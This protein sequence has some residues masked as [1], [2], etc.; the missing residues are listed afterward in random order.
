MYF[1]EERIKRFAKDIKCCI[2]IKKYEIKNI[3]IRYGAVPKNSDLHSINDRWQDYVSG[4]SW[5]N[6]SADVY[7]LFE[8]EII[9]PEEFDGGKVVLN[10]RTNRNGWNALNPQMLLYVNSKEQQ[11]LDT[12]HTSF[13]LDDNAKAGEVYGIMIYAF[14]G[15]T[16]NNYGDNSITDV[17]FSADIAMVEPLAEA[18]YYNLSIPLQLLSQLPEGCTDR[19]KVLGILNETVNIVD[20]RIPGS[21]EFIESVRM[22]DNY[23]MEKLYMDS[24]H[25]DATVTCIGHTHIDVAWLWR[26]CHTREKAVRSFTTALKLMEQY[27]EYIFMSSQPQLYEFVKEDHP[28]VYER[29]RKRVA[30]GRWEAEGGMWVEADTNIPS[31][32]SLVRQFLVGKKFFH[33]EFGVDNKILWLPDVFGYSGNLP[34]IMKKSGIEYFMTSKLNYN[35]INKFPYHTFKWKGIDGTEVLAHL[36]IYSNYGYN[37]MADASD[38][39]QGWN[40]YAQKDINNDIL[41]PCGYGDGGGGTTAEMLESI[42]RYSNGLP[43][44]PKARMGSTL[45]FFKRLEDNVKGITKLPKWVGELYFEYHRGTY[46]SM[47]KNKKNNRKA[48]FLYTFAEFISIFN[49]L[50]LGAAY[51]S[52]ELN[53]GWKSILLNQF[54]DVLPGSSIKEVYE[55]TDRIYEEVFENGGRV[56]ND[57]LESIAVSVT[58]EATSLLVFNQL[59]WERTG[60]VEFEYASD[61]DIAALQNDNGQY[62]C[63]KVF[64]KANTYVAVVKGTASKGYALYRLMGSAETAGKLDNG[65]SIGKELMEN[66]FFKIMLNADG[67]FSS[68]LDKRANR[69]LLKHGERGNVLQAFEDKPRV[70]DNWN[71]D[72]YYSEKMWEID[73]VENIEVL[74]AGPVR[75]VLEI[76]RRFL[77][78]RITQQIVIYND[79]PRVDFKTMMDWKEKDIAVKASFPVD[80][81]SDRATYE[82]QYGHI[83]RNTHW[84]TSWDIAKFEVCGHKWADLS[85][86][87]YG[88]SLMNDCKYGYDIKEGRM[89]LTLLR[90][91]CIPNPLADKEVHE[92]TYS[93]YPHI[94]GWREG[95]TLQEAYAL[96]CP[97]VGRVL[98]QQTG[99]LPEKLSFVDVNVSNVIV[100]V[101]KKSEKGDETII[102]VYEAYNKRS[103]A[104]IKLCKYIE[105]VVG[106]DLMENEA[107]DEDDIRWEDNKFSFIIKPLE[108]K[109]FKVKFL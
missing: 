21:K 12:N 65:I 55:D 37:C 33:E 91:G 107:E 36:V 67:T 41:L 59:S 22:A 31:G 68:V 39:V 61:A 87:G 18:F 29:I 63:Q 49:N 10:I 60:T 13:L 23:I 70:E 97:L 17:T 109:T 3:K 64:G 50:L 44:A 4:T 43:G 66:D 76:T 15:L 8:T 27:P 78:S 69:E 52:K 82:I 48:E 108:I 1:I 19:V 40:R 80:V 89:R 11:A 38:F 30:E 84:N 32:E 93:L 103:K 99:S 83:E 98:G 102:R 94:G 95:G 42:K 53:S 96:N 47:A 74:E 20:M 7:A 104:T 86:E 85:E 16:G 92:F 79:I 54:H 51:P 14:S 5:T 28:A 90:S 46:T 58:A 35:E 26:Y 106:C 24:A 62:I 56:L 81:N 34:Q 2:D 9:V 45:E 6:S 105:N 100:E 75:G 57:G 72:I 25:I 101:V 88:A 73:D 77:N 71:L